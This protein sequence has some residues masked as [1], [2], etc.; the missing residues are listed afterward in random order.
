MKNLLLSFAIIASA[1]IAS[2][3][4]NAGGK[5]FNKSSLETP[6]GRHGYA[7]GM[8]IGR[9]VKQIDVPLDYAALLQG[10][11]DQLDTNRTVLLN[12]SAF[13]AALQ[14]FSMEMQKAHVAKDSIRR[15]ERKKQAEENLASQN[16]F[17]EKN[18]SEVGVITTAS[19]LQYIVLKEG[20][21]APAKDGDT[22]SV[23][24][25]GTLPDGTKFDSSLDRNQPL[26]IALSEGSLIKGW[27]EMLRL[28]KNGDK[29]KVWVPSS[30]GYGE[31]G[32]PVIPGNSLLIFEMELLDVKIAKN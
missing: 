20:K 3:D 16:A 19:G 21:G 25:T 15:E 9:G 12:D 5:T 6:Q 23:H 8:D 26:S 22:I 17:L 11:K 7:I 27:V 13:A 32:N 14:E 4:L 28:M 31:N 2:C 24:Y 30:L 10:I 1:I 29:V 18:K